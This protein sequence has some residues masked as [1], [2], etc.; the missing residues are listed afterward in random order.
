M[1]FENFEGIPS[2]DDGQKFLSNL[3]INIY[4]YKSKKK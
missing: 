2:E 1:Y 4:L 3:T